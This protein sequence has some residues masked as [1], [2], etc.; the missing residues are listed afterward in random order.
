MRVDVEDSMFPWTTSV[1]AS[2]RHTYVWRAEAET[3]VVAHY[4]TQLRQILT[5][6]GPEA[7]GGGPIHAVTA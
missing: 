3:V 7:L 1:S 2:A 6:W 4:K 5:T